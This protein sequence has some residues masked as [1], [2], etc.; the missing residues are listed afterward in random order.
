[1]LALLQFVFLDG[2]HFFG[3]L[4]LLFITGFYVSRATSGLIKLTY[5]V[6]RFIKFTDEEVNE[7]IK[8]QTLKGAP[9]SVIPD[10]SSKP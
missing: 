6:N 2:F 3:C 4:I 1:M 7:M 9:D 5:N 8:K 10:L